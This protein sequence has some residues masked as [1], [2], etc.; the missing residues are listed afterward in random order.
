MTIRP[1]SA[2]RVGILVLLSLVIFVGA[3]FWLRSFWQWQ[4]GKWFILE[5]SRAMGLEAGSE[6][7]VQGMRA[8]TVDKVE[9]IP[10]STVKVIVRLEKTV[11]VYRNSH[12]TI[13]MGGL[14]GQPYLD[15]INPPTGGQLIQQGEV[16]R[17][18][19]P[20]S[21]EE[22]VPQASEITHAL[23]NLLNAPQVQ[24]DLLNAI[25]D[26]AGSA[27]AMR[28]LL[29]GVDESDVRSVV[30]NTRQIAER[31][32]R[33][34][35]DRRLDETLSNVEVATRQLA[36]FLS[37][38]L[39]KRG[40]P[41]TV[42]E[43]QQ[44]V[45]AFRELLADE[46]TQRNLKTLTAN[47]KASSESLKHLLSDEGVGGEL[48]KLLAQAR[49]TVSSVQEIT[50][51]PEIQTSLKMTAKNLA[52]LAGRGHQTMEELEA[53]LTRMRQ[54]I[55]STQDDLEKVAEHM[56]GITQ[57]LDETLD[58][59][60]WLVTEGGFKENLRQAGENL[61]VT[62]EDL[63]ETTKG[64]RELLTDEKTKVSLQQGLQEAGPTV[65][66]VRQTAERGQRLLQRLEAISHWDTNLS[67]GVWLVPERDELRGE[68][69]LRLRT[70]ASP[71]DLLMGTYT[72]R[73][74]T[75]LNLQIQ[76]KFGDFGV[77]R[78]GAIRSKLGVGLGWGTERLRWDL[79]A[80]D[81][82]RLQINSWLRWRISPSLSLRLGIEDLQRSRTFGVGMEVG[83]R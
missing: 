34:T 74:G 70:P 11:P 13:R 66:A 23:S 65:T 5:F 37:D 10:P 49:Q 78:F 69:M 7:F 18:T 33:F 14:I 68:T 51:D 50:T 16:V 56:R 62:T 15:I 41:K 39:L 31:L 19:D 83:R 30:T 17:G 1:S 82:D 25:A 12:I 73:R 40:V 2:F 55:E 54:F 61:K 52:E 80:F 35:A 53:T 8:G 48:K 36:E 6:V 64:I 22:M 58:A 32:N 60:K 59:I 21:W 26:L 27:K 77:W 47:L 43:A 44:A 9:L 72:D 79:E 57:D 71:A 29:A 67:G 20:L 63:R 46:E 42:Q 45:Q 75:Y 4:R 38:P 76:G 3:S 81:P 28:T 24:K